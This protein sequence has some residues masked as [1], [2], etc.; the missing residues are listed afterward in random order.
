MAKNLGKI[1]ATISRVT[2]NEITKQAVLEGIKNAGKIDI[3][4]VYA[5]Q[6]R[7]ILDRLVGYKVSPLLWKTVTYGLSA[8]RVQSVALRLICEREDEI[9]KFI[10]R[11]Y[12]TIDAEFMVESDLPIQRVGVEARGERA[13]TVVFVASQRQ[14]EAPPPL[15]RQLLVGLLHAG[16]PPRTAVLREKA[17]DVVFHSRHAGR[18]LAQL[19]V[20]QHAD[21]VVRVGLLHLP[22]HRIDEGVVAIAE[23][24]PFEFS[25][26]V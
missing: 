18:R 17:V 24:V 6:A 15:P 2:F 9:E 20:D 4:L 14:V 1:K 10:P 26:R 12:W 5:Q 8:G 7:R 13:Q 19:P 3:N 23:L 21:V 11:E 22:R 16:G 25:G